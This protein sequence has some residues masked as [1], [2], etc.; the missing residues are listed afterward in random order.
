MLIAQYKVS[1]DIKST[2]TSQWNKS[3]VI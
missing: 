3:T 2:L 1:A